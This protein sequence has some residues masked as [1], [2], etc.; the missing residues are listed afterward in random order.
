MKKAKTLLA[1]LLT[2]AVVLA[3]A[4]CG[5]NG[6][7][8]SQQPGGSSPAG[9]DSSPA[10]GD[11]SPAGGGA[12]SPAGGGSSPAGGGS[13]PAGGGGEKPWVSFTI[14]N[15]AW[16]GRF[17]AGLNPSESMTACDGVFDS[18]TRI[19]PATR[20]YESDVLTSFGFEDDTTY[21][22]TLRDDVY[23]SNGDHATAEDLYFSY[24]N[25]P[26]RG[27]NWLQNHG[28]IWEESG[29]RDEYTVAFKLE[30][31]YP[32]F[33]DRMMYLIDKKWSE[34]VGWDSMDWY[35]PVGS[36]PYYVYEYVNDSHITLR[37][38]ESR[39]DTVWNDANKNM[40]VDEWI[41]KYYP[42]PTTLYMALQTGEVDYADIDPIDY[43]RYV[44]DGASAPDYK[45]I[46]V[47]AGSVS[48]FMFG[49]EDSD[50]WFDKRLREAVAHGVD[51][52]RVG[53]VAMG[54]CYID[55]LS[56]ASTI[57]EDY[58]ALGRYEYNV[59]MAKDLMEQAGYGPNKRLT[60][61]TTMM[62]GDFYRNMFEAVQY[63][64]ADFYIDLSVDFAD[65]AG[66]IAIWLAPGGTDCGCW[67]AFSGSPTGNYAV[68]INE[69]RP[70][71]GLTWSG[72]QDQFVLDQY[73]ILTSSP[74]AAVRS[75]ATKAIQQRLFDE[76]LYI[77]VAEWTLCYGWRT[78][79]F[80]DQQV[81][82]N[83]GAGNYIQV[84]R[85]GRASSWN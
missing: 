57:C 52:A 31:P 16:L 77:P 40:W 75:A 47:Q 39:G 78:A 11:S 8:T 35:D 4:A 68:A 46:N 5:G 62:N 29:P 84:G 25:H 82:A 64:F 73:D 18:I 30:R 59:D 53:E 2:L 63:Y 56:T 6:T 80:T 74:D 33:A 65:N 24:W 23:F 27:S 7:T 34:E 28:I 43:G 48:Y 69:I 19:N 85:W 76:V 17:L 20:E 58:I 10:G 51:W 38:R 67:Y 81:A 36:G 13:N 60:L 54:P 3:I 55:A 79:V 45:L 61:Q 83:R 71:T 50:L 42:D 37:T 49:F 22:M 32:A 26:E 1:I 70:N 15:S 72:V 41:V 21:V 9:G 12:S 14:G 44:Q 66:A